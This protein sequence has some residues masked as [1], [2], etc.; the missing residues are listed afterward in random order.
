MITTSTASPSVMG[1]T[2]FKRTEASDFNFM[3]HLRGFGDDRFI[4]DVQAAQEP[5]GLLKNPL[6]TIQPLPVDSA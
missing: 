1:S 6:V 5:A 2:T 4:A 3:A